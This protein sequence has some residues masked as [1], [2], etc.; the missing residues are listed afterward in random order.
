MPALVSALKR[1]DLPT[2]G[3]PTI[4]HFKDMFFPSGSQGSRSS[5][6]FA[7]Q[8]LLGAGVIPGGDTGPREVAAMEG[9]LDIRQFFL[10]RLMQDEIGN[11]LGQAECARMA[12]AK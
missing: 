9:L 6:G 3:R 10:A 8:L 11:L 12:D 1:V 4:P 7:V 2:L 5:D